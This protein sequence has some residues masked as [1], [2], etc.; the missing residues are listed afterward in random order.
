M[1]RVLPVV[2]GIALI[3]YA[4]IDCLR[5]PD[6]EMPP[7]LPKALW[8]IV[9]ALVPVLGAAAWLVVSRL[10][11]TG[12]PKALWLIVIALVPVLG[13]AAWLV[14]SRL[15]ATGAPRTRK[16]RPIAPDD[17][18]EFLAN[19]DWKA[20]KAHYD[21]LRREREERSAQDGDEPPVSPEQPTP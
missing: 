1:P 10:P 4:F 6:R 20:R 2:L 15:P 8:L 7:G 13:A 17:D 18:P 19:L 11:A 16:P 9:I 14:V 12:P 5:M 21:Q 3:V